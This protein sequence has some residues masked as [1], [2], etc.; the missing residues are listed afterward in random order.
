M[1]LLKSDYKKNKNAIKSRL[2]DF[3]KFLDAGEEEIFQELCF[4]ILTPQ[5]KAVNCDK[6]ISEL[7]SRGLI[8]SPKRLEISKVLKKHVR[9]HNNKA[10]YIIDA[11]RLFDSRGRLSI[12]DKLSH[13][14]ILR[15][16]DWFVANVKGISYKE[17]SHFLR[18]IGLGKDI[19]IIDRHI[20]RNLMRLKVVSEIPKTITK[21]KY[22]E[23]EDKIKKFAKQTGIPVEEIDLLFWS[24]ETGFI[25]K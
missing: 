14:N 21:K 10:S 19:A 18:N 17:A 13:D 16:R 12:K 4:C 2:K 5:S 9:F 23:I 8:S 11:R 3:K 20:L 22:F 7:K 24:R 15:I 6:A 1:K 25:F